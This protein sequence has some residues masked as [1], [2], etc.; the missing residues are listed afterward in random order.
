[1]EE[2][3]EGSSISAAGTLRVACA[4]DSRAVLGRL[5][6]P[7]A[8]SGDASGGTKS[9][10]EAIPL[11]EDQSGSSASE[12]ARLHKEHPDEPEVVKDGRVL[13]LS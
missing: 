10:W 12:I 13:G 3:A 6:D 4:G 2:D 8:A 7:T 9:K 5:A 1:M 11:S